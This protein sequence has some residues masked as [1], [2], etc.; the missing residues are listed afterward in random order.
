M[1]GGKHVRRQ[2]PVRRRFASTVFPMGAEDPPPKAVVP[3]PDRERE[4]LRASRQDAARP[5]AGSPDVRK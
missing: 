5:T 4:E 3:K 1:S 2:K